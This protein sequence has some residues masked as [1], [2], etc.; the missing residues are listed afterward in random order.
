MNTSVTALTGDISALNDAQKALALAQAGSTES[1]I[2]A[3]KAEVESAQ[4]NLAKTLVVAPFGG[5]VTKM[6]AKVGEIVSP[7]TS[8]ISMQSDGLFEVE[9]YIPEISIARVAKGDHA[10]TTLDAYGSA[11]AFPSVVVSVD[12]AETVKDGVPTYKTTL[13]FLLPDARIRS[14]MTANVTIQTGILRD[15]IVIPSG[16]ITSTGSASY[17]SVTDGKTTEKRAV[18]TG[19]APSLGQIQILTGLSSGDT[20]LLTP[21][22]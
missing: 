12:P 21:G 13:S 3:A 6:D 5:V 17:V 14:G 7:S 22:S 10:S 11:I 18:T 19:I 20:I 8:E 15:A 1:D 4:A 2:A 9:T 16:A